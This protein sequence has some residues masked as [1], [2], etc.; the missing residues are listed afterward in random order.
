VN[1]STKPRPVALR[2]P[3]VI[4]RMLGVPLH[5]VTYV[6]RTR[7]YICPAATAGRLRVFDSAGIAEIRHALNAMDAR[8][9]PNHDR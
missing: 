9:G 8:R 1:T 2:T 6:L 4:A 3:G 7:Q 5:R